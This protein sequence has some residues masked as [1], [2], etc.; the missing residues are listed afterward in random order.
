VAAVRTTQANGAVVVL[1]DITDLRK[2]ERVRATLWAII[3]RISHALHRNS[4]V[5]RNAS[6][7]AV[8]D[9]QNRDRF[10]ELFW[11][12]RGGWRA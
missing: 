8:N 4:G 3:A 7:G 2:L 12:T 5:L 1:H 10:L 11:S 6:C 9:P